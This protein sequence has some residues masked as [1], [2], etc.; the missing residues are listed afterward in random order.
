[1]RDSRGG[2][3]L[4]DDPLPGQP[5]GVEGAEYVVS[6]MHSAH[7]DLRFAIDDLVAEDDRVTIRWTLYGTNT[8]PLWPPADR[9]AGRAGGDRDFPVRRRSDHGAL[10]GME[11]SSGVEALT[12]S[13]CLVGGLEASGDGSP[14]RRSG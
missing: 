11:A 14:A 12:K 4:D 9:R 2:D 10:G 3:F 7:P 1:M 13:G 8:G 5:A 6:T